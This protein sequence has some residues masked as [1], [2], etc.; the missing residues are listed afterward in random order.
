MSFERLAHLR[1]VPLPGGDA[2]VR[3]PWRMALSYLR[4]TFGDDSAGVDLGFLRDVP[5]HSISIVDAMLTRRLNCIDTSSCGRLFDA[6]SSIV[7][8]RH[9]VTFEGQAAIQLE[10]IADASVERAYPYAISEG[11][12][13]QLDMRPMIEAIVRDL[14]RA[15]PVGEIAAALHNTLAAAIVGVCS[16]IRENGAL[17][18]VCL[19]GGTFQNVF[20][21]QRAVRGLRENG[22]EVFLH[23]KVPPN[24]GGIALGQAVIANAV[25]AA[26][27][28]S[29][30]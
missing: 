13:A 20:I 28:R 15:T 11:D 16:R 24:D 8:L 2:A 21:L 12:P 27:D 30:N 18:R 7:G 1:Y 17:T 25:L 4:D 5:K 23:S 22:F 14:A 6:I 10:M 3:Q 26:G 29:D 9:E 19:S